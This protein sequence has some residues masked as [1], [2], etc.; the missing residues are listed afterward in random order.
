MFCK[1]Y[2]ISTG[3]VRIDNG[4]KGLKRLTQAGVI[5]EP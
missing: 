5:L 3:L 4:S 1:S 2:V